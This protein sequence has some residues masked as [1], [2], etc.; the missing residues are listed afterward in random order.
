M[1]YGRQA[2]DILKNYYEARI[3]SLDDDVK[4]KEA[5]V[6]EP[7]VTPLPHPV[8]PRYNQSCRTLASSG[9]F[10]YCSR[11]ACWRSR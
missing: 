1:G 9:H 10:L 2:L 7:E 6:V 3:P 5:A 8:C 11:L 4:E